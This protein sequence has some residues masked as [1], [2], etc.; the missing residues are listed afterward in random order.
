MAGYEI[1][2]EPCYE[3]ETKSYENWNI[4]LESKSEGE[5]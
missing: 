2:D 4:E 3:F 1:I 5:E